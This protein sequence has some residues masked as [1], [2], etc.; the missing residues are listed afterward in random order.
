MSI[1]DKITRLTVARNDIRTALNGKGVEASDHGFEDFADDIDSIS[2]GGGPVV[3]TEDD[4]NF[5]DYDGTLIKSYSADAFANVSSLPA[6][7]THEGLTAEGWNW[8][9]ADAKQYV[10]SYGGLDIGQNYIT[11]DGKTR[12][13]I[14]IDDLNDA[15]LEI[16]LKASVANAVT[17]DW[18]DESTV[19][20]VESTD[21]ENHKHDYAA[22]GNYVIKISVSSGTVTFAS[23]GSGSPCMHNAP[24]YRATDLNFWEDRVKKIEFGTGVIAGQYA[25]YRTRSLEYVSFGSGIS[26]SGD[27][28]FCNC[29][30]RCV[31]IPDGTTVIPKE[32]F[33]GMG[34]GGRVICV[35]NSVTAARNGAFS[36]NRYLK[37]LFL[38]ENCTI[39]KTL[40][41]ENN[42]LETAIMP[43]GRLV[44]GTSTTSI[45]TISNEWNI[46]WNC[47]HLHNVVF[48]GSVGS[49]YKQIPNGMFAAA[50]VHSFETNWYE[51]PNDIQV[52]SNNAF[53]VVQKQLLK[54]KAWPQ[55]IVAIGTSAFYGAK[56][57]VL[58]RDISLPLLGS[59][60]ITYIG[61]YAFCGTNITSVSN[62]GSIVSVGNSADGCT[63]EQCQLL[64][65]V[66]LPSTCKTLWNMSFRNCRSLRS[67]NLNSVTAIKSSVFAYDSALNVTAT[68]ALT[69]LGAS[70][71]AY[72]YTPGRVNNEIHLDLGSS[73]FTAIGANNMN[74]GTF[75]QSALVSINLPTTCKTIY[76]RCFFAYVSSG[77]IRTKL[78]TVT[79]GGGANG[80]LPNITTINS[81]AFDC[82]TEFEADLNL[83]AL[84]TLGGTNHFS[85]S[86]ITSSISLGSITSIPNGNNDTSGSFSGCSNLTSVAL[87]STLKT[88]GNTA[89]RNCTSLSQLT[90]GSS[91]TTLGLRAFMS[92][93][94][95][96]SIP[97]QSTLTSIGQLCFYG[98][99]N[100]NIEINMPNL[101]TLGIRA[102]DRSGI[103]KIVN[104]GKITSIPDTGGNNTT[105]TFGFNDTLTEV[106]LP[107][108]LTKIG[109]YAF[110][111]ATALTTVT[112]P[113]GV[114][115]IGNDA[116]HVTA[117]ERIE[118]PATI[119]SLGNW[120]FNSTSAEAP[121]VIMRKT[122]PPTLGTNAFTSKHTIYVPAGTS[123][124]YK[125]ATN[126]KTWASQ[127]FELDSNGNI[128]A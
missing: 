85:A 25:F 32:T 53:R 93:E 69:E 95:L 94:S 105:S 24:Y 17:I 55:T 48:G 6:N 120:W 39:G 71:F 62:L 128:P 124:A 42:L 87:P 79:Q 20:T 122:T 84:T 57:P 92:C 3:I 86:G 14:E 114:T 37:R 101:T 90:G 73:T 96:T 15:H 10:A 61:N 82:T 35:P 76:N 60:V 12:I 110:R 13:Y 115:S 16:E 83:P 1:A 28:A 9:L 78:T 116:F 126:W 109:N 107:S 40:C 38:P 118:V 34:S 36:Y 47:Y 30:I 19:E 75:E 97:F 102:F 127:I 63:F 108:T 46:F 103:T 64:T 11:N 56:L 67:I 49:T 29:F 43:S 112:I 44:D 121:I 45:N 89:F 21:I 7:P 111:S 41:Y 117:I 5:W 58:M 51:L 77:D 68:C 22:L 2:G 66:T 23:A 8:S 70:A 88:I 72:T 18:G 33:N 100:L 26:I 54:N 81:N 104:L 27:N 80:Y 113:S 74:P 99:T 52:I 91:V 119:T 50:S 106:V 125:A 4:V 31:V 65:S 98:T 59:A 123:A